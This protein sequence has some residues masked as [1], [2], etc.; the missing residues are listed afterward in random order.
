[1]ECVLY[2]FGL[3]SNEIM[4]AM[5]IGVHMTDGSGANDVPVSG[6]CLA[7]LRCQCCPVSFAFDIGYRMV[8][9]TF[10]SPDGHPVHAIFC[11]WSICQ[12]TKSRAEIID[13]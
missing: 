4:E 12:V 5:L 10:T 8:F 11:F 7:A 1:M 6:L 13:N 3:D 9:C 2:S